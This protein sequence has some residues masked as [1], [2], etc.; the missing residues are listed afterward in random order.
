MCFPTH[1][2]SWLFVSK[3]SRARRRQRRRESQQFFNSKQSG[4]YQSQTVE[5]RDELKQVVQEASH[6]PQ[7][8]E[9]LTVSDKSAC[10]VSKSSPDETMS[11]EADDSTQITA[12]AFPDETKRTCFNQ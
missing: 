5:A 12:I 10:D 8:S 2:S 7:D 4:K 11:N 1:F 9:P 3:S 6:Q